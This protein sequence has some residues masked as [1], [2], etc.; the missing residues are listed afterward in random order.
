MLSGP[1]LSD[2]S[3]MTPSLAGLSVRSATEMRRRSVVRP[4][5]CSNSIWAECSVLDRTVG[6]Q[7]FCQAPNQSDSSYCAWQTAAVADINYMEVLIVLIRSSSVGSVPDGLWR[8]DSDQDQVHQQQ[9]FDTMEFRLK[10]PSSNGRHSVL[11]C[12]GTSR[13][14]PM[15]DARGRPLGQQ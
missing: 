11:F 5:G 15:L 3:G 14:S 10:P 13:P 6:Q 2:M 7:Y 9:A 4:T 1:T 12:E 8:P